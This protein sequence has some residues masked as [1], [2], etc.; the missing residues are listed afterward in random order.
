M[1]QRSKTTS[2]R[3]FTLVEIMVWL[4][5]FT[6]ISIFVVGLIGA[7]FALLAGARD[8]AN[9]SS[10]LDKSVA[11]VESWINASSR[12]MICNDR[13]D[14]VGGDAGAVLRLTL[15][16]GAVAWV[17]LTTTGMQLEC[18]DGSIVALSTSLRPPA[19]GAT[20]SRSVP[21]SP[22]QDTSVATPLYYVEAFAR[23]GA[24]VMAY[25]TRNDPAIQRRGLTNLGL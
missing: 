19:S 6:L 17:E 9:R 23:S 14:T 3:A 22:W 16:S 1:K 20:F 4:S 15:N 5:V 2:K 10:D 11:V 8:R 7:S 13:A 18:P 25:S 12:V 24:V 21:S